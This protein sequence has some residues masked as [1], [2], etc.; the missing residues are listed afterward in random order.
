MKSL[1]SSLRMMV[2]FMF[3]FVSYAMAADPAAPNLTDSIMLLWKA[4]QD[5]SG[6][7]LIL[8]PVF[9]ILR[10]NESLGLLSKLGGK[11][12]QI[13]VA[14][15]TTGGFIVNAWA[16]GQSLGQAAVTGLFTAGGAMLIYNAIRSIKA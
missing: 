9:Q 5:H 10:T 14:L 12:M 8:V 13:A 7:A 11:G 2:V 15:I 4:I 16:T 6:T 3:A 1:K